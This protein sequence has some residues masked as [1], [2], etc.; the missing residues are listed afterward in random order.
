MRVFIPESAANFNMDGVAKFGELYPLITERQS[1]FHTEHYIATLRKA[2]IAADYSPSEDFLCLTGR[3][4]SLALF[5]S[6]AIS[7]AVDKPVKILLYDARS[8]VYTE[9]E[10]DLENSTCGIDDGIS[11]IPRKPR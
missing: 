8:E 1:P 6:V 11:Q 10:V 7:V 5:L 2:L 9:R 4:I 3:S